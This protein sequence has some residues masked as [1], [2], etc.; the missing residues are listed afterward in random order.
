YKNRARRKSVIAPQIEG[1]LSQY[2]ISLQDPSQS[3]RFSRHCEGV[4]PEAISWQAGGLLS[5]GSQ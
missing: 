1:C 2:S 3:Q 4:L 5:E